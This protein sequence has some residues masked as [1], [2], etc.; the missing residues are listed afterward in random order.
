ML[1]EIN[2]DCEDCLNTYIRGCLDKNDHQVFCAKENWFNK[3]TPIQQTITC[4]IDFLEKQIWKRQ[5]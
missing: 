3:L 1:H 2:S 5:E 4:I